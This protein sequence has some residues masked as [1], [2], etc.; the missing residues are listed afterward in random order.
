MMK[1]KR[2]LINAG[3]LTAVFI[4][5]VVLFSYLTNRGNDNMTADMGAATYPQISFSCNGYNVNMLSGYAKKMDIPAMRD[6]ITPVAAQTLELNV[7]AY[8]NKV[9]RLKYTVYTLDGK[10]KLFEKQVKNVKK[11][12]SLELNGDN[13]LSQERVLEVMLS[14][15]GDKTVYFYTRIADSA[16]SSVAQCLDYI[17][18]FHEN[19]LDKVEGAGIGTAIEPSEEGDNSTFQ[20]VTIHSDYNQVT[21]GNLEPSVEGGERWH[22]KEMNSTYTS[23]VLEY[24]VRCKGE[25][26]E[27]DVYKVKEFF[28][29]RHI[30]DAAKTYLLDYDRTMEQIFDPTKKVLTEKGVLL[31]IA[32]YNVQYMVNKDGSA[33]SFVQAD[34][35]WNYYKNTDEL[36]LVFSFSDAEN[37]DVRNLAAKHEVR[38][39]AADDAGNTTFAVYGYMNRGEH[40]GEVGIAIYYYDIEKNS[41]EEKAFISSDKSYGSAVYELGRF[42]Y[43]NVDKDMLYVMVDGSLY[44]INVDKKNKEKKKVIIEGLE[45]GQYVVSDDGHMIAYQANGSLT[46]A[47]EIKVINFAS[48]KERTVTCREDECVQPLG[49]VKNDFVYGVAKTADTGRT[50]SGE[51]VV[52]MY[53][54]EIQNSKSKVVKTY[55]QE[56]SYVLGAAFEDNM[57]TLSRAKKEG[58]TYTGISDDYV[59]NNEE[60]EESNIYLESYVTELKETQYRLTY[61]D[62]ISDK[63]PKV[64]KPKQVLFENPTAITFDDIKLSDK[65]YVYGYG[66]LQGVFKKA[67]AAIQKANEY[68]GVVI[69]AEQ[70]YIWERGN[71]D[72]QHTISGNDSEIQ[73][74]RDRLNENE[75]PIDIM[76]DISNGK[77]L[78][79][80][81]CTAEELLYIINKDT[82]VVAM[83][84]SSSSIILTGYTESTVSYIETATGERK[85][86][87]YSSIDEMTKASGNAYVGYIK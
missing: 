38:L 5:A 67:G 13:L 77:G 26:N 29:V 19:A 61:D 9:N 33:V 59:T 45:E 82:P 34:E 36:S 60:K 69:S 75:S 24:K 72:L 50:V 86:A 43:Y 27:E 76:N 47:T 71:R 52:P 30:S 81:G 55:E 39:L 40:E 44:E 56:A 37:T 84:D 17:S 66:E 18:S 28:R 3:I 63:E 32:P 73:S 78:D 15:E 1:I 57:I 79:L 4:L 87:P 20:H 35:L 53:K 23:V 10:E 21:W 11:N 80:S 68:N 54:V 31:G 70:S 74:I 7:E 83:L 22:I 51:T 65:C 58:N 62:G 64:L 42:V 8:D 12:I 48:G 49:F 6:T 85:N 2:R 16:Q 25:E 46:K 41:V 14:L